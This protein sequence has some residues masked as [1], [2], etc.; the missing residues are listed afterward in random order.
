MEKKPYYCI[1]DKEKPCPVKTE[2]KLKPE[3]LAEFCKLCKGTPINIRLLPSTLRWYEWT[4]Q[5]AGYTR[6][7]EEFID[8]CVTGYFES[9]GL[10]MAVVMMEKKEE[11]ET[12]PNTTS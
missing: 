11:K 9:R 4:K 10:Q 1:F 8:N 6:K 3:S 12:K 5:Q 2:Y 7:I